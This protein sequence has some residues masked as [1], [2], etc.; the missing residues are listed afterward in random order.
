[1]IFFNFKKLRKL[2]IK[3]NL[4][5]LVK[6]VLKKLQKGVLFLGGRNRHV[7]PTPPAKYNQ[8]PQAS[9]IRQT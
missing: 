7:F 2:G 5:N 6:V 4:L 3:E 9:Y 1:M 8:K